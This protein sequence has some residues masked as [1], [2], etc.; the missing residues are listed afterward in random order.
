MTKTNVLTAEA[1]L[2]MIGK[3]G[4]LVRTEVLRR[5]EALSNTVN[6]LVFRYLWPLNA[7]DKDDAWDGLVGC[8]WRAKGNLFVPWHCGTIVNTKDCIEEELRGRLALYEKLGKQ[9]VA[10]HALNNEFKWTA[11]WVRNALAD[12]VRST[13]RGRRRRGRPSKPHVRQTDD[14]AFLRTLLQIQRERFVAALGEQW[15]VILV[16]LA[17]NVPLSETRRGWKSVATRLIAAHR[18]VSQQQAR[19]DKRTMLRLAEGEP[20][21]EGAV[22]ELLAGAFVSRGKSANGFIYEGETQ[23]EAPPA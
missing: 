19:A 15:W 18:G 8:C 6:L 5:V 12:Y 1:L 16:V 14:G 9:E 21:I 7:K 4:K 23:A 2:A 17:A 3:R 13:Y 11:R 20:V 22:R 10:Q